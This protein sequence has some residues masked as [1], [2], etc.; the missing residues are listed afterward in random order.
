MSSLNET[1][2]GERVHIGFFGIR[3]AGKSSL[4]NK[5]TG[6][7]LSVVSEI[8]GTTTDPVKKA[9]ELLP[10]GPVL[11]IDTPGF[12]DD[13]EI[14]GEL[15]VKKTREIL[16]QCDIAVLVV[17]SIN[18]ENDF[19]VNFNQDLINLFN[20]RN[21]PYIIAHNKA[22]LLLEVPEPERENE[23]YVS[24]LN[25]LNI[26]NLK[27]KIAALAKSKAVNDKRLIADLLEPNDIV[28][29]VIP[30]DESAPK[31]RLILPQQQVIRD[32]L[33]AHC[34]ALTCQPEELKDILKFIKPKIVVTDSQAFKRVDQDTPSDI[35]LTSFS[36]LFARYKGDLKTLVRGANKL[37]SLKPGDKVLISEGCTHHRQCGDIGT[38]KI[39]ALIKKFTKAVPEF[40]FT[41]GGEFPDLDELKNYDLIIHCGGCMLNDRE[42]TNRINKACE[43]GVEIVNYGVAIACM[44]GI[45]KRSIE[46]FDIN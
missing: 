22:D 32:I 13:S 16:A 15:R 26:E 20:E 23:I 46:I 45:L 29:L 8:K 17:N 6:Q 42:M 40:K 2:S 12:D 9:M 37:S 1:P 3:N 34:I 4:V 5:I 14:L 19:N 36:I 25:G 33:D 30:I 35:Y 18:P 10:L 28:V 11:I 31:G 44:N 21:I 39:P 43:A 27:I 41:S 24:A 7:N 38:V